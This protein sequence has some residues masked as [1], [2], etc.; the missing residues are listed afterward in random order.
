M[1]TVWSNVLPG[2]GNPKAFQAKLK[3]EWQWS[4][5]TRSTCGSRSNGPEIFSSPKATIRKRAKICA[6]WEETL[7]ERVIVIE[8]V[9]FKWRRRKP[10]EAHKIITQEVRLSLRSSY[11]ERW[12]ICWWEFWIYA[13]TRTN[14]RTTIYWF[15]F[16]WDWM[17]NIRKGINAAGVVLGRCD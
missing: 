5:F 10:G 9:Y 15:H 2:S 11:I 6:L 14:T 13:K 12:V 7:Y 17:R 16:V 4:D 1:A 3:I 8:S